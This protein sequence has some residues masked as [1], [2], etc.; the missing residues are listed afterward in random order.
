VS[1]AL[2]LFLIPTLYLILEERFPR[3]LR[4]EQAE[5]HAL[6]VETRAEPAIR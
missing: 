3:Q 6:P 5:P 1:T 2:T 4:E